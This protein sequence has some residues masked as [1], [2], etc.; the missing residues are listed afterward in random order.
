MNKIIFL[1]VLIL[2]AI[3]CLQCGSDK[4]ISTL[5]QEAQA[6]LSQGNANEAVKLYREAYN[7]APSDRDIVFGLGMAYK[8]TMLIDSAY[9]YFRKAKILNNLDR[10]VNQE[11]LQMAPSYQDY[12]LALGAISALVETGDNEQMYWPQLSELYYLNKQYD[13]AA[14]YYERLIDDQPDN[15]YYYISLAGVLS[16]GGTPDE[17]NKILQKAVEVIGPRPEFYSNIAVNYANQANF[18]EAEKYFRLSLEMFS[19]HVPSWINLANVL[20]STDNKQKK[21][22]ALEIYK[23]YKDQTPAVY[24]LDSLIPELERELGVQ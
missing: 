10:E 12:E 6:T 3:I 16:M 11:I 17:A 14:V 2:S 4:D 19:E 8:R 22:E 7:K 1:S 15:G 9:T 24:N 20:S 18:E 13:R 21:L 23:T 5:K